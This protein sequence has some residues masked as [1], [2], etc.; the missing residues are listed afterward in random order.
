MFEVQSPDFAS[1]VGERLLFPAFVFDT[2][3]KK[4]FQSQTREN[5]VDLHYCHQEIDDL[6]FETPSGYQWENFPPPRS[7]KEAFATYELSTEKQGTELRLKRTFN[8]NG[9]FFQT[10]DYP[11]LHGFFE[12][13]RKNDEEQA[14]LHAVIANASSNPSSHD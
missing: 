7:R 1:R 8:M 10:K 11:D 3:L 9:Y 2:P 12:S 6:T 13:L 14:V 5:I 4:A